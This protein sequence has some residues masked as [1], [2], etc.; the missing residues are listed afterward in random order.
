MNTW[1][2]LLRRELWEHRS[3]YL[4]PI[5]LASLWLVSS[6]LNFGHITVHFDFIPPQ[7][8]EGLMG[9]VSV[10]VGLSFVVLSMFLVVFYLL[11]ALYAERKDRSILFWKSLPVSDTAT[12]GSKLFVGVVLAPAIALAAALVTQLALMLVSSVAVALGSGPWD[13]PF[14]PKALVEIYGLFLYAAVV[15]GLWYLPVSGWLL[16][17][18]AWGKRSP[19]L[20]AVLPPV[21]IMML[22]YNIRHASLL[23]DLISDRFTGVFML[24][25]DFSGVVEKH[26]D[27]HAPVANLSDIATPERVFASPGLWVGL[28]VAL[29][30]LAGAVWLRRFR[31]DT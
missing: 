11:D 30:F 21:A 5:V 17:V 19:T 20:W 25:F 22:E 7:L 12:V 28:L 3:L 26:P 16:L 24:A 29:V 27:F 9:G 18:S 10:L 13:P 1:N 4:A 8:L 2:Y 6:L 23:G 15:I 31:D 14:S